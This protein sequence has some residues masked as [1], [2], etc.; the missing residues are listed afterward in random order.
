[1][2]PLDAKIIN[3]FCGLYGENYR[4]SLTPETS[5][6]DIPEW[7]SNTFLDFVMALEDEYNVTFTDEEA[8]QMFQLGHVQRLVKAAV[9][10][11][12]HDD[13][14]NAPLLAY[15]LRRADPSSFN[16]LILSGSSTREGLLVPR[17]AEARLQATMGPNARW[18]NSS[19]SG[20]VL[21]ET[22]QLVELAGERWKGA[23][24]LGTSPVIYAGCGRAEFERS[25]NLERFPFASGTMSRILEHHGYRPDDRRRNTPIT[26]DLWV[27]RYLKG[28]DLHKLQYD[29]YFYPTLAPWTADK[30]SDVA[31]LLRFYN[32]SILNHAESAEI[33]AGFYD[34]IADR[35]EKIGVPLLL[36]EL[37]LH[38][39]TKA[40]LESLAGVVTKYE[41]FVS[42]FVQRRGLP[43]FDAPTAAGIT[44]ADFRDPAHI[45]Q[46]RGEYTDALISR[47]AAITASAA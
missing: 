8:T 12:P 26:L 39:A 22:L 30:Y 10:N 2:A 20:L 46:K 4:G 32:N 36:V 35:C 25:V 31:S 14:A 11:I 37:T 1:M 7:D 44:D 38:S 47:V 42:D 6:N 17:E 28:R 24:V 45:F 43:Y 40:Y 3:I 13:V 19:A 33:N 34:A 27:E 29:P 18:Y 23:I 5:M 41:R 9:L 16:L 21:A 15:N